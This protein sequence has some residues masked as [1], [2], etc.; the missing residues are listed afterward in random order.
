[1]DGRF[2]GVVVVNKVLL[3]FLR[4]LV[5]EHVI[6]KTIMSNANKVFEK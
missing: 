5:Q 4:H 2:S 6:T 1:M 3:G